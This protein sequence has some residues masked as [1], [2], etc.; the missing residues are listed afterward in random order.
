MT[1]LAHVPLSYMIHICTLVVQHAANRKSL[2]VVNQDPGMATVTCVMQALPMRVCF[3]LWGAHPYPAHS[4]SSS[5]MRSRC[6]LPCRPRAARAVGG[7][8]EVAARLR[9]AHARLR[10][11][12]TRPRRRAFTQAC[13]ATYATACPICSCLV[14]NGTLLNG[15]HTMS[16][17]CHCQP[18]MQARGTRQM[19]ALQHLWYCIRRAT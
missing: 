13:K 11:H 3:L 4:R 6:C 14:R 18:I 16:S 7:G 5:P 10:V 1:A 15:Q 17:A 2:R 19:H 9:R 12:A 8:G